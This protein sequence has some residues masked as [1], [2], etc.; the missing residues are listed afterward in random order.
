M[1]YLFVVFL[2]SVVG[3]KA[4][5]LGVGVVPQ[6]ALALLK[7]AVRVAEVLGV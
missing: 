5:V 1:K 6:L 2:G 7:H 4:L 3:E